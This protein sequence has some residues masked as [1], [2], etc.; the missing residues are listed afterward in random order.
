MV[1]E[2]EGEKERERQTVSK[3]V[4]PPVATQKSPLLIR[5]SRKRG[6]E[7]WHKWLQ[8][9]ACT[10]LQD[11]I[12]EVQQRRGVPNRKHK[13]GTT[14]LVL[15]SHL[16][17]ATSKSTDLT[18]QAS[19]PSTDTVITTIY[20]KEKL[21]LTLNEIVNACL[22]IFCTTKVEVVRVGRA[23]FSCWRRSLTALAWPWCTR[24]R[25]SSPRRHFVSSCARSDIPHLSTFTWNGP[26]CAVLG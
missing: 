22:W 17:S 4:S 24:T 25:A 21:V 7:R 1:K 19:F 6:R 8:E 23:P 20:T 5:L 13:T 10:P 12:L 3:S 26:L 2:R 15:T 16:P 14:V 18:D 9:S 11:R